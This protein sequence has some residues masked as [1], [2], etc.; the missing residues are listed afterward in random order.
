[1]TF[2]L[3]GVI[4]I[5]IGKRGVPSVSDTETVEMVKEEEEEDSMQH[6]YLLIAILFAIL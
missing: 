1:M 5:S 6:L 3:L 2:I 4:S